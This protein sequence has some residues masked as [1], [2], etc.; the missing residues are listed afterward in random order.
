[1]SE[2]ICNTVNKIGEQLNCPMCLENFSTPKTLFCLH[3]F[4]QP[5]LER[6]PLDPKRN[7]S[8]PT[9]QSPCELPS[10]GVSGLPTAFFVENLTEVQDLLRRVV[11]CD[12]VLCYNCG[13]CNASSYCK[14]CGVFMCTQC[15]GM[16]HSGSKDSSHVIV[17]MNE[18]ANAANSVFDS[19]VVLCSSH[20][21]PLENYC[22]TCQ[23]LVCSQCCLRV[24][25]SHS[26]GHISDI[27][28]ES[29]HVLETRLLLVEQHIPQVTKAVA[30][31][32]QRK[33]DIIKSSSR[34]K[35]EICGSV[36]RTINLLN[37]YQ[38]KL[39]ATVD[40]AMKQKLEV[41]NRQLNEAMTTLSS[42]EDCHS[43]M[44]D[45]LKRG[46]PQQILANKQQMV[47]HSGSVLQACDPSAFTPSEESDFELIKNTINNKNEILENQIGYLSYHLNIPPHRVALRYEHIPLV[48]RE[49][50]VTLSFTST[51]DTPLP[52]SPSLIHCSITPPSGGTCIKCTLNES[53]T[54]EHYQLTFTPFIRGDH[55]VRV[56]FKGIEV[57]GCPLIV[58]VSILPEMRGMPV[59]V[60]EDLDKPWGVDVTNNGGV[61][62]SEWASGCALITLHDDLKKQRNLGGCGHQLGQFDCPSGI[63]LTDRNTIL[64]SDTGN[65]RIQ[66]I[67]KDGKFVACIGNRGKGPLEFQ[68]PRG[69]AINKKTRQIYVADDE[70]HRIQVLNQ[71]LTFAYSFGT[72][73]AKLGQFNRPRD[74]AFDSNGNCYITDVDNHRVQK[75]S[76]E[77]I[78]LC[79]FGKRGSK[80]GQLNLPVGITI[81]DHDCVYVTESGNQRVSVFSTNGDFVCCF[82]GWGG[83]GGEQVLW[84]PR[85]IAIDSKGH[86]YVCD[87]GKG[88]VMVF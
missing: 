87:W 23:Q 5:C 30:D 3:T 74:I 33:V 46:T 63:C 76:P 36:S 66:E 8:C 16:M 14:Q 38:S 51:T 11:G 53:S 20:D 49:S 61:V 88:A 78:S 75:V 21:R 86:L 1:M 34:V 37:Q 29:C 81:D 28:A 69:I 35:E 31:L 57:A 17:D 77:G 24:H 27:F 48:G 40:S 82:N 45:A 47:S 60:I 10:A 25:A 26:Y 6:L 43:Y 83:R 18:I 56:C 58:P 72:Y 15:T 13:T 84:D 79:A 7:L 73:G 54:P 44:K 52:L 39:T 32:T 85:E 62:V 41:I 42:L 12:P 80:R 55:F 70:N 50:T 59:H 67:T 9:C 71:D 68:Y 64:V 19:D 2:R 4:C 65:N 22:N